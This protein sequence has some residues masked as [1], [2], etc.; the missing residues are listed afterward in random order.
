MQHQDHLCPFHPHK[1]TGVA[2]NVVG[3]PRIGLPPNPPPYTLQSDY[4]LTFHAPS[5]L[6]QDH[7]IADLR[8]RVLDLQGQLS[9]T[10]GMLAELVDA[11]IADG[12]LGA[13]GEAGGWEGR[14]SGGR[15]ASEE[16]GTDASRDQSDW[17]ED[18]SESEGAG[19]AGLRAENE[20][21][22]EEVERLRN[23]LQS[24]QQVCLPVCL[25]VHEIGNALEI[26]NAIACGHLASS[27][28]CVVSR[29]KFFGTGGASQRAIL[30]TAI[31]GV[32]HDGIVTWRIPP[33]L[34][35]QARRLWASAPV[36]TEGRVPRSEREDECPGQDGRAE[37]E[38]WCVARC[39]RV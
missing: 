21:L 34:P 15:R 23:A 10:R 25:F 39:C 7:L 27:G 30:I 6:Q 12:R 13:R 19:G 9:T 26:G 32:F 11:E 14:A 36:R 28:T 31:V 17:E 37:L 24:A 16:W 18:L 33:N 29:K 22:K 35:N 3:L 20:G 8:M 4:L 5:A 2:V 38:I 1:S